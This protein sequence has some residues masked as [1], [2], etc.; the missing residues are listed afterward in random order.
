MKWTPTTCDLCGEDDDEVTHKTGLRLVVI[1]GDD[2]PVRP[3]TLQVCDTCDEAIG[4]AW[5]R[6][7][8]TT[9]TTPWCDASTTR[10]S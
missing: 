6:R 1:H 8:K 9:S 10:L 3:R 2:Q 7:I 5:R 4:E